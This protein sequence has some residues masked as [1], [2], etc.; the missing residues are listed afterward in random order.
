MGRFPH[1]KGEFTSLDIQNEIQLGLKKS[2]RVSIEKQG[3]LLNLL[4]FS[5]EKKIIPEKLITRCFYLDLLLK[6]RKII[7]IELWLS[8]KKKNLPPPREIKFIGS[9]EVNSGCNTFSNKGNKVSIWRKEELPKVLIHELIHSL[10]LERHN[11]YDILQQFVY[12]YFD[13]KID[14]N[15]NLFECYVEIMADIVNIM[16]DGGG[17]K[18]F[19]LELIHCVFQVGKILNYFGY[20]TWEEFYRE[21]GWIE[22]GKTDRYNQKSNV[23]SY[24][25]MRSLILYNLDDFITLCFSKNTEHFLKQHFESRLLLDIM[26]KTLLDDNYKNL[27]NKCINLNMKGD[28]SKLEYN[29]LRMTCVEVKLG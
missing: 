17:K 4:I 20:T 10:S 24:F 25:I 5:D 9:K 21:G 12:K 14:N 29:N 19:R 16:I 3:I 6:K 23:F 13:V 15:L 1:V 27:V 18:Y 28:K 7:N 26:K 2:E 11:D 8:N 22:G